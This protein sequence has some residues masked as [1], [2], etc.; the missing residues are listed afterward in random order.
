M[1][2]NY[3]TIVHTCLLSFIMYSAVYVLSVTM[4]LVC[5]SKVHSFTKSNVVLHCFLA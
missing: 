4:L 5:E 1:L 3:Y 2:V